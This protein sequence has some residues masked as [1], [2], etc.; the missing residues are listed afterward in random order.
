MKPNRLVLVDDDPLLLE[1][2]R[3]ICQEAFPDAEILTFRSAVLA[4]E[5]IDSAGADVLITD[6]NMPVVD[7]P[8]LV[9]SLRA[10]GNALPIIMVSGSE[11]ALELGMAAGIDRFVSKNELRRFLPAALFSLFPPDD[12]PGA[13]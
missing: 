2:T 10:R 9:R 4:L 1:L 3:D 5:Q 8:A 7:G 12:A 11:D 6:C 13:S